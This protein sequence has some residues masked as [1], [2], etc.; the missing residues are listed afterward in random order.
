[1]ELVVLLA[2]DAYS[3]TTVSGRLSPLDV[4]GGLMW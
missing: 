3:M 1:L 2:H 4:A